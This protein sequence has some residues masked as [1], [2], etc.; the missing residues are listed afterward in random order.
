M[1]DERYAPPQAPLADGTMTVAGT[2]TFDLGLAF[3]EAWS[4][5]WANFGLL[6]FV[7]IAGLLLMAA[8]AVTV[9]G[10]FL[11]VPVFVWG[12]IRFML[13]VLDGNAAFA[14]L[15][16]GFSDYGRI[17]LSMLLLGA[18]SFLISLLGQSLTLI[19]TA[20]SMPL[21]EGLGSLVNLA[22]ALLVMARLNFAWFFAVDQGMGP[23]EALQ[24]S[25]DATSNLKGSCAALV[26]MSIVVVL[27]GVLA[28]IVGVV[29]AVMVAY[30]L[31]VSAYRQMVGRRSAAA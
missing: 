7:G 31:P 11:L 13:N 9:I 28:L 5:T 21:L 17:L 2:G 19:G 27:I 29:P 10:L 30:L 23:V 4:A 16:S 14:D 18:L 12:G 6:L 8:S 24:A 22:W 15:F 3:N 20:A 25:W 1:S 26:V